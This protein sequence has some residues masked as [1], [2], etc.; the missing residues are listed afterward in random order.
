LRNIFED[1]FDKHPSF[2]LVEWFRWWKI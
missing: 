1:F 2:I